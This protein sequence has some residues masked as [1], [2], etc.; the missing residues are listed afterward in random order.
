M[1]RM[2]QAQITKIDETTYRFT[3]TGAGADVYMYLL[4]GE[5]QALLIDTAFGFTDVPSAIRSLTQLP[6]IVVNTHGHLDHIHGNHLY[7]EVYMP[8]EDTEVFNRHMDPAYLRELLEGIMTA[9][10]LPAEVLDRPEMKLAEILD[11]KPGRLKSL[12]E[13]MAF[14]LGNR[15][16]SILKTPGHT[17]GSICLLDEKNNWLFAA[18]TCCRDGVLLHFPESTSVERFLETIR[19][20]KSIAEEGRIRTIFPGH[21]VT[22]LDP[23]ILDLYEKNCKTVLSGRLPEEVFES[24]KYVDE[25]LA[26]QFDPKHIWEGNK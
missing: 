26:I 12:P 5:K 3:E 4:I 17:Q 2:E 15:R 10:G 11:C 8:V 13:E 25:E 16:I 22:P 1:E 18:D 21:Q 24:G 6:L 7:P 23:S 19:M 9:A 14:E 20:L